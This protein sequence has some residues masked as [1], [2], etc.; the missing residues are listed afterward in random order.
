[1]NFL[2]SGGAGFIGSYLCD[3]FISEG[4]TILC[5]DNL[6][7]GKMKNIKHLLKKSNFKYLEKD[8]IEQIDINYFF[9]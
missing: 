4:H 1:M 7:S 6:L 3:K 8:I 9:D 5:I 2:I